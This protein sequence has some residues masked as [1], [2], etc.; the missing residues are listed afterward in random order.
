MLGCYTFL[1]TI[2]TPHK[3]SDGNVEWCSLISMRLCFELVLTCGVRYY[4]ILSYTIIL[5]YYYT[6]YILSYTI[7]FSSSVLS[8]FH[9]II[10]SKSILLSSSQ[11]PPLLLSSF[12]FYPFFLIPILF[13]FSSPLLPLPFPSHSS[14]SFILYVSVLTYGYLYSSDIPELSDPACFIGVDG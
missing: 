9:P 10:L 3:L 14:L 12:S 6:Y 11:S 8:S 2:L 13:P 7:L 5:L 1:P 4:Y